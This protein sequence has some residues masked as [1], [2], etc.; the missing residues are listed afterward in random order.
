DMG[1]AAA[2][3][4]LPAERARSWCAR[5]S[6]PARVE[7]PACSITATAAWGSAAGLVIDCVVMTV[8]LGR[9]PGLSARVTLPL[10]AVPL[11]PYLAEVLVAGASEAIA[12]ITC[13]PLSDGDCQPG[14]VPWPGSHLGLAGRAEG[15]QASRGRAGPSASGYAFASLS[16][17]LCG[18]GGGPRP[19]GRRGGA[20]G[21][22][23]GGGCGSRGARGGGPGPGQAG[24]RRGGGGCGD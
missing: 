14:R 15:P 19:G 16:S 8:L 4:R 20:G 21:P 23:R 24:A 11:L 9:A 6:A 2:G 3:E 18:R 10:V 7:G 5:R 17:P 22:R 1:R 12:A 13:W